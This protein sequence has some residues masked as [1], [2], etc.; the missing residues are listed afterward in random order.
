MIENLNLPEILANANENQQKTRIKKP[1]PKLKDYDEDVKKNLKLSK[2]SV[3][4]EDE[5]I[6]KEEYILVK[7]LVKMIQITI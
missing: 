4:E 7:F 6:Q 5:E 1:N 3:L 2:I